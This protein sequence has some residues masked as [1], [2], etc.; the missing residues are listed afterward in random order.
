MSLLLR[1]RC[2]AFTAPE[3]ILNFFDIIL[4]YPNYWDPIPCLVTDLNLTACNRAIFGGLQSRF[5]G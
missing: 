1:A 3:K 5:D 4:K 2:V